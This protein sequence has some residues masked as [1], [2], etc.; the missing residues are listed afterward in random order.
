[1]L[2]HFQLCE[3]HAG[4]NH[5]AAHNSRVQKEMAGKTRMVVMHLNTFAWS[6]TTLNTLN[7][8]LHMMGMGIKVVW[9]QISWRE[10]ANSENGPLLAEK[11]HLPRIANSLLLLAGYVQDI[12]VP[13]SFVHPYLVLVTIRPTRLVLGRLGSKNFWSLWHLYPNVDQLFVHPQKACRK[14][15]P[16]VRPHV[17]SILDFGQP[18]IATISP[19]YVLYRVQYNPCQIYFGTILQNKI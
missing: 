16:T 1:M 6:I 11:Y 17:K 7:G 19:M 3:H 9:L 10:L 13:W 18:N 15:G 2:E 4:T 12:L 5:A 14:V 8:Q